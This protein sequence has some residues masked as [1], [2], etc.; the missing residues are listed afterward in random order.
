MTHVI[1]REARSHGT[2]SRSSHAEITL[3]TGV[4]AEREPD[5]RRCKTVGNSRRAN[6]RFDVENGRDIYKRTENEKRG[7]IAARIGENRP[8]KPNNTRQTRTDVRLFR[9]ENSI[10]VT[11]RAAD[12]SRDFLQIP[13]IS[14]SSATLSS[15][16]PKCFSPS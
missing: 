13:R 15:L 4:I 7:E 10:A 8:W 16:R 1:T 2:E 3:R 12:S 6:D 11:G 5:P 9:R 14:P